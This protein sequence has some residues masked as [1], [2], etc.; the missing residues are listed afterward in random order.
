MPEAGQTEIRFLV[1]SRLQA[2]KLDLV[3]P[4][5]VISICEPGAEK[6]MI[7]EGGSCRGILRL[8]FHDVDRPE[9]AGAILF[10]AAHA[11]EILRFVESVRK[12]IRTLVVH[13]EAGVSRSAGVAAALSRALFGEDR[14]FFDHYMP[15]RLVYSTLLGAFEALDP[16]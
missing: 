6:A 9:R 8:S 16:P 5:A 11:W 13:C 3:E 1:L 4:H 7:P 12:D 14:F 15:N 2:M 10:D